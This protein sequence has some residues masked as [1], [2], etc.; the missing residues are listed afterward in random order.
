MTL[1]HLN[2]CVYSFS[3][4]L[5]FARGFLVQKTVLMTHNSLESIFHT[6]VLFAF[7]IWIPLEIVGQQPQQ[8]AATLHS[9]IVK[10]LLLIHDFPVFPP[11]HAA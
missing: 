5:L 7:P 8:F 9:S 2:L 3:L 1:S 11:S 10:R 4:L 6:P